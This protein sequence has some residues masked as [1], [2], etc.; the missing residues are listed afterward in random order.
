MRSQKIFM[1]TV[2]AL[3]TGKTVVQVATVQITVNDLLEIGAPEAVLPFE[4]FLIE[5]DKGFKMIFHTPVIIRRLRIS[6]A[7]N[8][9]GSRHDFSPLE[10]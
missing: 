9:C 6:G 3:H 7:I 4:P 5:L 8:G 1:V 2:T 10:E